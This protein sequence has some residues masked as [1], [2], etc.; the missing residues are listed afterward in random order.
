ML[1][2]E[3]KIIAND[4]PALTMSAGKTLN[5]I[6]D[7]MKK[8]SA[9]FKKA[10]KQSNLRLPL[11]ENKLTQIYVEQIEVQIKPYSNIGVKIQ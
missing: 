11:N 1:I 10:C 8:A 4:K 6:W 2:E 5:K 7:S 9:P 3:N